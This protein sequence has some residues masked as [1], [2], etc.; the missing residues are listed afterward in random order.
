MTLSPTICTRCDAPNHRYRGQG[1]FTCNCGANYNCFGQR[2]RDN[3]YT[4]PN[5]SEYDDEIGDMEGYEQAY[6]GN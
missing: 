2:L 6:A 5:L 3:L 1:D 4:R